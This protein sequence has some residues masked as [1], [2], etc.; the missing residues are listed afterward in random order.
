MEL[1]SK[2]AAWQ[3]VLNVF[4][5]NQAVSQGQKNKNKHAPHSS[6]L[7]LKYQHCPITFKNEVAVV[8]LIDVTSAP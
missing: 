8:V 3:R 6:P 7:S 2:V 4:L 1:D 5:F